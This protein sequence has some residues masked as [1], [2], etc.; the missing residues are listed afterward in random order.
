MEKNLFS[1]YKGWLKMSETARRTKCTTIV[2]WNEVRQ[3][4]E[5]VCRSNTTKFQPDLIDSASSIAR[6]RK[7][8]MSTPRKY[9]T[10][11]KVVTKSFSEKVEMFMISKRARVVRCRSSW[12]NAQTVLTLM[13][14]T[15]V[16]GRPVEGFTF[17]NSRILNYH[18]FFQSFPKIIKSKFLEMSSKIF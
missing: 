14:V 8:D 10:E 9:E 18:F 1:Y 11:H 7:S 12:I 17:A 16:F 4:R 13:A 2:P 6:L 15:L 5:K 3:S